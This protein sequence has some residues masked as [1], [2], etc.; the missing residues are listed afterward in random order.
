MPPF[1][2]KPAPSGGLHAAAAERNR[3]PILDV[4]RGVLPPAGLVLEIASDLSINCPRANVAVPSR[5]RKR[6]GLGRFP[7]EGGVTRLWQPH[8]DQ[9][10]AC[11]ASM[12]SVVWRIRRARRHQR[13]DGARLSRDV[14]LDPGRYQVEIAVVVGKQTRRATK[15]ITIADHHTY[16]VSI[17][18]RHGGVFSYLPVSSY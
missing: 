13:R 9:Y 14:H 8:V 7:V 2:P 12:P 5:D 16:D 3:A 4:L 18:V 6:T 10:E 15:T 11:A 17:V 1:E